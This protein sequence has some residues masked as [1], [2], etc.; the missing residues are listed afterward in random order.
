MLVSV[1]PSLSRKFSAIL[2]ACLL[3]SSLFS[4]FAPRATASTLTSHLPISIMGNADF[5][6]ANGVTGGTGTASDPYV[7]AG[8]DITVS[9][10]PWHGQSHNGPYPGLGISHTVAHFVIRNVNIYALDC[11]CDEAE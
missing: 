1:R 11:T 7:I 8:W 5:T 4:I 9:H 2:V 3:V 6:A 10:S